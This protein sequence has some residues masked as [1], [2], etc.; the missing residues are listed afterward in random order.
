MHTFVLSFT[1]HIYPFSTTT[2]TMVR[3]AARTATTYGI[4][5]TT[6]AATG[7]SFSLPRPLLAPSAALSLL[8]SLH[9]PSPHCPPHCPR[10]PITPITTSVT[11]ATAPSASFIFTINNTNTVGAVTT[12]IVIS[13][14]AT[15]VLDN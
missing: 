3:L 6:T 10:P 5:T 4:N 15:I 7:S 14:M 13:V 2:A 11:A 12:T 1:T 8:A 9:L